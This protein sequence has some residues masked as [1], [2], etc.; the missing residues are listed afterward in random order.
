[1]I[2]LDAGTLAD[3]PAIRALLDAAGLPVEG[4]M[5]VPTDLVVARQGDRIVAAGALEHHGADALIR[6]VV[7]ASTVRSSGV[8]SGIVAELERVAA[9][10]GVADLYLLTETA[11]DFFAGRGYRRIRRDAAPDPVRASVEWAE[12]CGDSAVPMVLR[13]G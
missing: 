7:V 10:S 11:A 9:V 8:G 4:L 12:V 1:V 6:S 2:T 5:E 13:A 3:L